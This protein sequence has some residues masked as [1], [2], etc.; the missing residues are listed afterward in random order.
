MFGVTSDFMGL[1][2]DIEMND[3]LQYCTAQGNS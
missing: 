2:P 3:N 1:L